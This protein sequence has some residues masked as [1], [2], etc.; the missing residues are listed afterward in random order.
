MSLPIGLID[1]GMGEAFH[2]TTWVDAVAARNVG[3]A[4]IPSSGSAEA[5]HVLWVAIGDKYAW[6]RQGVLLA[7]V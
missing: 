6:G 2:Q 5:E 4:T 7:A 1:V 3:R